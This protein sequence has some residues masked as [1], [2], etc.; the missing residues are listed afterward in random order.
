M[1]AELDSMSHDEFVAALRPLFEGGDAFLGRLWAERPF[2]THERLLERAQQV[3]ER[4]PRDLQ[5]ALLDSHPRIGAETGTLSALSRAEQ[6]AA[7]VPSHSPV[8]ERLAALN[9]AYERRFGFHYVIR[10]AGRPREEIASLLEAA[11]HEGEEAEL[12]RGL[13]DVVSIARDRLARLRES[14]I[15]E[16][17]ESR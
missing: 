3:A 4:M 5:R 6:G 10:V 14:G 11:L 2:G 17:E 9:A 12:R 7:T 15:R 1:A 16:R 13:R 8:Q